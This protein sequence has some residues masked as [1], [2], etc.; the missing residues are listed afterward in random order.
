MFFLLVSLFLY[1]VESGEMKIIREGGK[2]LITFYGGVVVRDSNTLIISPV[3]VYYQEEGI[4][5]LSGPVQGIQGERN[6]RCGFAKI[7]ERE[8]IFMGYGNCEITGAGEFLKSDSVVLKE[9]EVLA[10]GNVFLRSMKDSIESAA[11]EVLLKKDMIEAKGNSSITYFG[12]KDTVILKS[13]YYLYSDSVLHASKG[14][15]ITGKDFEGE[16]DSLVYMRNHKY[17]EL[18]KNAWVKNTTTVVKGDVINLYLTEENKIER[19]VAFESPSLINKEGGKEIYLEGDSLYFYA[20]GT[21]SLRWFR[22]SRVKGYYKEE[23][24]NGGTEGN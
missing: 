24:E 8:K 22:A 10:Y 17:A 19:L 6:L 20:E 7:Y 15:R 13:H 12:G 4:M 14:V 3:A 23:T 18:L 2:E 5:E 16:G 1:K 21:D 9:N 11:E